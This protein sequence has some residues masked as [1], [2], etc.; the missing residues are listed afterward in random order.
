LEL[1]PPSSFF[2]VSQTPK[3]NLKFD[4]D[5]TKNATPESCCSD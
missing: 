3:C 4:A 2:L 5:E 1:E